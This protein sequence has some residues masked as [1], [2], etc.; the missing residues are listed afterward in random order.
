[1]GILLAWIARTGR[2]WLIAGIVA[3]L[4]LPGAAQL[5]QPWI[6]EMV[7]LLLL[8]TGIR[9]GARDALAL[10]AAGSTLRR[11]LALQFALPVSVLGLFWLTGWLD[12]PL[13]LAVALMLC[14]PSLAGA[15]SFAAMVGYDPAPGLR[16][17][18]MGTALFPLTALPAFTLL[19]PLGNGPVGALLLA[20]QLMAAILVAVGAGF[21]L[22]AAFPRLGQAD[23]RPQLE[24]L[25]AL[26]LAIIVVGL[27]SAVGPMLRADPVQLLGWIIAAL[28]INFGLHIGTLHLCRWLG[29]QNAVAP[30]IFAGNRNIA[31]FLLVLPDHI[32]APLMIFIG[33][34]QI[35]MYLTPMLVLRLHGRPDSP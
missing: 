4:L 1:M 26:L 12:A 7:A 35:P 16:I 9:V 24:G 30:S 15:P 3:G 27:M 10:D 8:V 6:G 31:L 18:V 23:A 32:A 19:D 14:A 5:L 21:G 33:C 25:A 13:C 20:A 28:A 22:R 17:L 11:V 34:Y 2:L 29:V